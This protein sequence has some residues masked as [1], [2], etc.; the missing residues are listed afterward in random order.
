MENCSVAV[1]PVLR[2]LVHSVHFDELGTGGMH[3][4]ALGSGMGDL[5]ETS[6]T[7]R[8]REA[9]FGVFEND[10]RSPPLP[11]GKFPPDA[12]A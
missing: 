8:D 1:R 4:E 2:R 6:G 5:T 9:G 3:P 12:F 11:F 10:R 7:A